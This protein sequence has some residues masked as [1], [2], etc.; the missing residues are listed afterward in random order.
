MG[1]NG[2][3]A[4]RRAA[5]WLPGA[6]LRPLGRPVAL[7]FHGVAERISDPRIEFNHHR[8]ES[9]CAIASQLKRRFDVLPLSALDEVMTRPESYPRAVF[10]MA[11]DGYANTLEAAADILDD[12]RL[13]WTLFISTRHIETGELNPLILARLFLYHAPDGV[14]EIPHL[15]QPLVLAG[16]AARASMAPRVLEFLKRQPAAIA[17]ESLAAM[18]K[19]FSGDR[20]EQLLSWFGN[21]R[22]LTWNNVEALHRRGVDIGAHGDWHWPMN[23]WQDQHWLCEQASRAR[24]QIVARLGACSAFA[25]PLGNDG[26]IA[27]KAWHAVRDA[28]YS[29]AFTTLSGTLRRGLNPWLLPRYALRPE[30]PDLDSLLP[31]LRLGNPRVARLTRRGHRPEISRVPQ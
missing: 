15:P 23:A 9:F 30:E 6:A 3:E 14:Y 17:Q 2:S 26:D 29:H 12:L 1:V 8:R 21:E 18:G 5:H 27:P 16:P 7:F 28:G 13:S 11:D 19:A 10:L 25:Y 31:L 22:F 20:F 24:E 4:L